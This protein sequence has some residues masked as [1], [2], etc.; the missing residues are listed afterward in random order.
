MRKYL[1]ACVVAV[2]LIP[3]P[4]QAEEV[5][6]PNP[7]RPIHV[8]PFCFSESEY[9]DWT[10]TPQQV[11][12]PGPPWK[13]LVIKY[14]PAELV[15]WALAIIQCES[16]GDPWAKN[17]R[18]TAAGLFQFLRSTWDRGPAPALGLP[19]YWTGAPYVAEWNIQAAAWLYAN[20]GGESQWS[21][22]R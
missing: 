12:D 7:E 16:G 19:A 18:S 9:L 2:S 5:P 3:L 13:A 15:D 21:C 14:W 4:L 1:A 11:I 10:A 22:K 17:P 8:M 6:C 20:W